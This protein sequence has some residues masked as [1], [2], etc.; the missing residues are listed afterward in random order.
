MNPSPS[1]DS[2]ESPSRS[3]QDRLHGLDLIRG[4]AMVLGVVL[5]AAV[6]YSR[7]D[8]PWLYLEPTPNPLYDFM[9]VAI[10]VFRMPLFFLLAGFFGHLHC[11]RLGPTPYLGQRFLRVGLPF[12][13]GMVVLMPWLG[14]MALKDP[15][16]LY[17]FLKAHHIDVPEGKPASISFWRLPT[18]HLWF[19]EVLLLCCI[20]AWMQSALSIGK[21]LWPASA[22]RI[23]GAGIRRVWPVAFLTVPGFVWFAESRPGDGISFL[24]YATLVP[25]GRILTYSLSF[26]F[27][28]WWL[29]RNTSAL[30][31]LSSRWKP[32]LFVGLGSLFLLLGVRWGLWQH[33]MQPTRVEEFVGLLSE[34]VAAWFLSLGV[35]AWGLRAMAR[36]PRWILYFAESSYWLYFI[37][38]PLVFWVQLQI[39]SWPVPIAVKFLLCLGSVTAAGLLSYHFLVRNTWIGW[40]FNGRRANSAPRNPV[41]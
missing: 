21:R 9:L 20:V 29:H 11:Q 1:H 26:F 25:G 37:H 19:L 10:H 6:P 36:P 22:D 31:D 16:E 8:F 3:P 12:V 18:Y 30:Q 7:F 17:A 28:G 34:G 15:T 41:Q 14:S 40:V 33:A 32:F 23:L 24:Q 39:R 38:L 35:F 13:I 27:V 5:H 4:L 2:R